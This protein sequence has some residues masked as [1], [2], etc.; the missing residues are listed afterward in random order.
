MTAD[1]STGTPRSPDTLAP[2]EPLPNGWAVRSLSVVLGG[3]PSLLLA[4]FAL[5]LGLTGIENLFYDGAFLDGLLLVTW[6]LCG[7]L[8]TAAGWL[9]I[10][11]VGLG[12]RRLRDALRTGIVLGIIAALPVALID[13]WQGMILIAVP[14]IGVGG[15]HLARLT[16]I[17]R[18]DLARR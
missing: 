7:L 16:M 9:A 10:F 15:Y 13:D 14:P 8:G 11:D 2:R 1:A 6:C 18:H 12:R 4:V 3:L 17:G 5:M